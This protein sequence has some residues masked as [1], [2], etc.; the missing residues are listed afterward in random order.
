MPNVIQWLWIVA[1]AIVYVLLRHSV[2]LDNWVWWVIAVVFFA[3][4]GLL[5]DKEDDEDDLGD[6]EGANE[7]DV[8]GD[9]SH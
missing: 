6:E 8:V 3:I 2:R 4:Y 7:D 5:G 1:F 9:D